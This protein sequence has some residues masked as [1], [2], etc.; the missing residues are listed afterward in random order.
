[1]EMIQYNRFTAHLLLL[2]LILVV[3][4]AVATDVQYCD[5]QGE[6]DVKVQGVEI[7][8]NPIAR[9][10]PATFSIAAT[11]GAAIDGGKLVIEVAYFGWHI[12]SETHDLCDETSCPVSTGD[13]VVSHSQVLP[14]YTP[15]GLYSLKMK[16]F[17][18]NKRELTCIGFDFS[19][20]FASSVAD[21]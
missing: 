12:H 20:G 5:K 8:P 1:M 13:F 18:A 7:S 21:S 2:S 17:D 3:P 16:M 9:G 15:P 19:I 11:T 4:L 6:Y 14:G 10:Q